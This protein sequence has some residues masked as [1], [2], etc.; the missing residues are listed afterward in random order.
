MYLKL[1]IKIMKITETNITYLG[2]KENHHYMK[3]SKKYV[4]SLKDG[5]EIRVEF[6]KDS[7]VIYLFSGDEYGK[8]NKKFFNYNLLNE[9]EI[10]INTLT[11]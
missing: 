8:N 2:F 3:G 5:F 6:N 11:Y 4:F 9:L 7:F 1:K 10:L